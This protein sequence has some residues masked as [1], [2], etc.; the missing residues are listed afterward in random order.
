M[1]SKWLLAKIHT[2]QQITTHEVP[3]PAEAAVLVG[4][5]YLFKIP[6]TVIG[7]LI[8]RLMVVRE[9]TRWMSSENTML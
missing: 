7:S 4:E 5:N 9:L 8:W 1:S 3:F 2:L 6:P